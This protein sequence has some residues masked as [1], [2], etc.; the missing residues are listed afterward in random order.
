MRDFYKSCTQGRSISHLLIQFLSEF[1]EKDSN[2]FFKGI[3]Q[4]NHKF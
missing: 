2:V 1:A 4:I 3:L